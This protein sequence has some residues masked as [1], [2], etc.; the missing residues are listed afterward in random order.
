MQY[1]E[2][3]FADVPFGSRGDEGT[4]ITYTLLG[5]RAIFEAMDPLPVFQVADPLPV[6]EVKSEG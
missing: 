4:V 2:H 6:F 3:T 5:P 1:G